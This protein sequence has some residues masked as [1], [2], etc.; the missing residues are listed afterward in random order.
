MKLN[1]KHD[2]IVII[3]GKKYVSLHG[4]YLCNMSYHIM[5]EQQVV[6]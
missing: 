2:T 1:D 5:S 3:Q 4:E 6:L